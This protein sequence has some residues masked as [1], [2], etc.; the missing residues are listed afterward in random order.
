MYA[1]PGLLALMR[2]VFF[3]V[4]LVD[5]GIELHARI[6]ALPSCF[7]DLVKQFASF[8]VLPR[9]NHRIDL[10]RKSRRESRRT[11]SSLRTQVVGVWKKMGYGF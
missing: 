5:G 4:C 8:E 6:A 10:V 3:E 2:A 11:K 7:P 9:N 1:L